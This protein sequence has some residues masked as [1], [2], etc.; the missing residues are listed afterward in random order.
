[1]RRRSH[2][3]CGEPEFSPENDS[4]YEWLKRQFS[5]NPK[6]PLR[7]FLTV[8]LLEKMPRPGNTNQLILNRNF[9]ETLKSKGYK[10]KYVEFNGAH[11]YI[12]WQELLAEGLIDLLGK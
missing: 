12:N 2:G 4:E 1:M 5:T 7:F 10:V 9:S 6:L 8:G 11:E 3:L